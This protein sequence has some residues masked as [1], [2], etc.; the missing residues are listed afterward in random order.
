[1]TVGKLT[2]LV[3]LVLMVAGTAMAAGGAD[4]EGESPSPFAGNL[5]NALWTLIIFF[6]VLFVL[7]KFA[8]KPIL[9]A[10]QKRESFIRDSLESAKKDREEA[11]VRLKEYEQRVRQARDEASAIVDE[12]R[13]DAGVVRKRI[14]EDARRVAQEML[15]RAKREIGIARDS[16]LGDLYGQASDLAMTL[17]RDVLKRELSPEDHQRMMQ[18][19]LRQIREKGV[20]PN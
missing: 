16:A 6:L 7:G 17:A 4:G 3:I 8:W 19:A 13:R 10:L 14:E 1:M 18:E 11:E 2:T 9:D 12:G 20:N 15:E 5:G